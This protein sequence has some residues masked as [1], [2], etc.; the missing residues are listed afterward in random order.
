MLITV[1]TTVICVVAHVDERHTASIV[2][3]EVHC[4]AGVEGLAA[5]QIF[6]FQTLCFFLCVKSRW[7]L[8]ICRHDYFNNIT[9]STYREKLKPINKTC[10]S[11]PQWHQPILYP[12]GG[13][14][15]KFQNLFSI[16]LFI[17]FKVRLRHI[18]HHTLSPA[19]LSYRGSRWSHHTS[20]GLRCSYHWDRWT[21]LA[22]SVSLCLGYSLCR[23]WPGTRPPREDTGTLHLM[24]LQQ[25]LWEVRELKNGKDLKGT[26]R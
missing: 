24:D 7:K 14:G 1:I 23:C 9:T 17:W 12:V 5:T 13:G 3:G 21:G 26:Q 22:D 20:S 15:L 11:F 2:A 16:R 4:W 25:R 6:M 19:H 18:S 8:Q 10:P